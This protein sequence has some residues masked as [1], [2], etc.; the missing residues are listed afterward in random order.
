MAFHQV[1]ADE[2]IAQ[3]A[4][5]PEEV[6]VAGE[7]QPGEVG[8]EEL[9]VA[10]AVFGRVEDGVQ[11][12]EDIFGAEGSLVAPALAIGYPRQP[13]PRAEIADERGGEVGTAAT[14]RIG[15][16]V[17]LIPQA[18]LRTCRGRGRVGKR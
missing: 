5:R 14:R 8:L 7:R 3:G 17:R 9:G 13:Q 2:L 6:G 12:V 1:E 10:L 15:Q 4:E 18:G 11:V 16:R